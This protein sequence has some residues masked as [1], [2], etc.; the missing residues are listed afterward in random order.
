MTNLLTGMDFGVLT[1][2]TLKGSR[3]R[4]LPAGATLR[5]RRPSRRL[6]GGIIPGPSFTLPPVHGMAG[7]YALDPPQRTAKL[8]E[9]SSL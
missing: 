8:F 9:C 3:G 5:L 1:K 6:P 4:P 7:H 2:N